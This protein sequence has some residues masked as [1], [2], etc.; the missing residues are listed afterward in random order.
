MSGLFSLQIISSPSR[1]F[2]INIDTPNAL[3]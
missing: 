1:T 3:D 2:G